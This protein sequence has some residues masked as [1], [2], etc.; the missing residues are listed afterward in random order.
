[1]EF[2]ASKKNLVR[3]LSRTKDVADEKSPQPA[4]H[5][6]LLSI[7]G[8]T[9]HVAATDLYL[10][11]SGSC[12]VAVR[13]PGSIALPAKD[14]LERVKAM[15]DGEIHFVVGEGSQATLKAV[16]SPRRY[17]LAGIPGAEFPKLAS[18]D[19]DASTLELS[20]DLLALLIARTH[21]SISTDETRS[22]VNSAL[23]E[24]DEKLVRMVSTDGHRLSKMEARLVTEHDD[25]PAPQVLSSMLVPLKAVIELRRLAEEARTEKGAK[26]TITKSGPNAFF[27][28]AG[29]R[30]SAKLVDAQ[31]PPYGQ[32][33][34]ADSDRKIHLPRAQFADALKAVEVACEEKSRL[35][36][37]MLSNKLLRI[38]S[39][40]KDA[41]EGI[42]EL[43]V[44][45][46][47]EAL[48]IGFNAKYLLDVL[49]GVDGD[50]VILGVSGELDPGVLRPAQQVSGN[51]YLCVVMPARVA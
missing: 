48:A 31:F 42:D 12:S 8:T 1:M 50:E 13:A 46:S 33:I 6:V 40:S 21:F 51:D 2:T 29:M 30:F 4:L 26:V 32:V 35:V 28:V 25:Q 20:A 18:P 41:G 22:H 39:K 23:F 27:D 11:I 38:E 43:D 10:G 15:P 19:V 3:L 16:G 5:N 24:W 45:Y 37:L 44:D 36:K 34:P 7:E 49:A 47:G 17:T 14:L 9:L